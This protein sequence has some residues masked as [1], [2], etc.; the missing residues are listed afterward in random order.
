MAADGGN[1][2]AMPS[3]YIGSRISLISKS[4][5]R[6]EGVLFTIDMKDSTIA[7]QHVRSY[8][9]EGRRQDGI[10]LPAS[11]ETFDYIIFRGSDIQDLTVLT[12]PSIEADPAI[13]QIGSGVPQVPS[14]QA[15]SSVYGL[16]PSPWA[17]PP[18][19]GPPPGFSTP[20]YAGTS[21]ASLWGAPLPPSETVGPPLS[22][23]QTSSGLPPPLPAPTVAVTPAAPVRPPSA[24]RNAQPQNA[25]APRG[26]ST[27][28]RGQQAPTMNGTAPH[29]V[30]NG[31]IAAYQPQAP[32]QPRQ[33]R[34]APYTSPAGISQSQTPR[35]ITPRYPQ[36]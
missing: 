30:G 17:A 12:E 2:E 21:A 4:D 32:Q 29:K 34:G 14:Q 33:P 28:S 18:S 6:Y 15:P 19:Q 22:I 31:D 24:N 9:T 11:N 1:A 25:A 35:G 27:S 5:V 36:P 3:S 8:G 26:W 13:V 20:M 16:Q 23:G 7:L 10:Q